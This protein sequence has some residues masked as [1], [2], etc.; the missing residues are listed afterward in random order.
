MPSALWWEMHFNLSWEWI[1]PASHRDTIP[2]DR[3]ERM[4]KVAGICRLETLVQRQ[5]Y[6]ISSSQH[7]QASIFETL[8]SELQ[9]HKDFTT[10][11]W[12][13]SCLSHCYIVGRD[14]MTKATLIK[15]NTYIGAPLHFQRWLHYHHGGKYGNDRHAWC[16]RSRWELH[17]YPQE[18]RRKTDSGRGMGF[19]TLQPAP[20]DLPPPPHPWHTFFTKDHTS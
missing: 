14:T 16:W 13:N 6:L 3:G 8:F 10:I 15:D 7:V 9:G 5:N 18:E 12:T 17:P 19:S 4:K 2:T 11:I 20:S 1:F